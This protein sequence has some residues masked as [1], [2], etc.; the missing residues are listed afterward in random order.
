[1]LGLL[2]IWSGS[3]TEIE[4]LC[5]PLAK[6]IGRQ[7]TYLASV[8]LYEQALLYSNTHIG[9]GDCVSADALSWVLEQPVAKSSPTAI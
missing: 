5:Q 7:F 8:N 3:G 4:V 1:M 2:K 9:F 6:P